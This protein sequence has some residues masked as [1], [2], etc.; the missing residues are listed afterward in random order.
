MYLNSDLISAG[1]PVDELE[2]I[3]R[4]GREM[5]QAVEDNL[6]PGVQT[7]PFK[8]RLPENEISLEEKWR[9]ISPY[10]AKN[11]K[12]RLCQGDFNGHQNPFQHRR[13]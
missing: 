1:M 6:E 4:P 2:R 13:D 8:E 7:Y 3:R 9:I 12:Y 11:S 5:Y 10:L